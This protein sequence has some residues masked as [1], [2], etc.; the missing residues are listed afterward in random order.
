MSFHRP[1]GFSDDDDSDSDYECEYSPQFNRNSDNDQQTY[2]QE[3]S[4]S[5][6]SL[7]YSALKNEDIETMHSMLVDGFH[8]DQ[9]LPG[10]WSPLMHA[11][12][13]GSLPVI[14]FL[15]KEG[16]NV[17]FN[18]E[19]F[20]PLM[21]LCKSSSSNQ[22][23]L[24]KG[25]DLLLKNNANVNAMDRHATTALM[26]ACNSGHIELVKKLLEC[27]CDINTQ[28]TLGM[29]ALFHAVNG[30]QD[31]VVRVLMEGKARVDLI[32]KQRRSA[33]DLAI[34]KGY[35]HLG[36]LVCSKKERRRLIEEQDDECV[37]VPCSTTKDPV[38][39]LFAQLPA[40]NTKSSSGFS[41]DIVKLLSAME[42][43]HF[44]KLFEENNV[45]LNEFLLI[46]DEKLKDLGVRFSVHRQRILSSLKKLHV[47]Q[48]NKASLGVK[49]RNQT[50][51]VG[52]GVK[53]MCNVTKH[54]HILNATLNFVR[55][56]QPIPI[57]LKVF[58]SIESV[59]HQVD[60]ISRE[61]NAIQ[62]FSSFL[63]NKEKLEPVDLIKPTKRETRYNTFIITSVFV[64]FLL[65]YREKV[66]VKKL[67]SV[68]LW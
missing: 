16:A 41:S 3:K 47:H 48:W 8:I 6:E 44:I 50:I 63:K 18:K 57:Q 49:P 60:L 37:P 45:Q 64:G 20:T 43:R 21:A 7:F 25:F 14:E 30:G 24:V 40:S 53:L 10:G 59:L 62:S 39:E 58:E 36:K 38:E 65:L 11:C 15:I 46:T 55:I 19:L 31:D 33:F 26:N 28:D 34:L 32:D 61:L 66:F 54:L 27:K 5:K 2:H 13:L 35:E 4:E 17:N 68:N 56:H 9:P 22:D 29:S 42:L 67:F 23:D 52:D 1:A 51:H 12:L